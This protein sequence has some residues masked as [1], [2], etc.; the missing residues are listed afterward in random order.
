MDEDYAVLSNLIRLF[1][2]QTK[3]HICIHDVSGILDLKALN[4]D[5]NNQIHS[6][7]FCQAAKST[8][9]GYRMCIGCKMHANKKAAACRTLFYGYCPYGLF[10]IAKPVIIEGKL[11][12]IIYMGNLVINYE[13]TAKRIHRTCM[14]TK[15][16]EETLLCHM[17]EIQTADSID[18]YIQSANF[19]DSY[20]RLLFGYYKTY[21][22]PEES[23][24]HWAV[25]ALRN[26]IN[27]NYSQNLSLQNVSKLYFINDKYMG[28]LFKKQ[29]GCTFHEYLNKVRL[30][31]AVSLLIHTQKSVI[32]IAMDCGFQNVTYFNR[33]FLKEH[34]MSPVKYRRKWKSRA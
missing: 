32:M 31:H 33:I 28:R 34:G 23:Q 26:Y 16:P 19:I 15:V 3:A 30:D 6:K 11:H 4:L 2:G 5:F 20:I 9:A 7:P 29:I 24:C 12:C 21:K 8:T 22:E 10:E 14:I 1:S 13:E 17:K 25:A 27:C 18:Y